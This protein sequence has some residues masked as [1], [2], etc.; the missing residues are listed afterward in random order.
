MIRG[1]GLAT[2]PLTRLSRIR[3]PRNFFSL[4]DFSKDEDWKIKKLDQRE[5]SAR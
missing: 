3:R 1:L 4:I 5:L 2:D